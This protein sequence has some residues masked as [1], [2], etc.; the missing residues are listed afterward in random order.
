M[1][2]FIDVKSSDRGPT[3]EPVIVVRIAATIS[4]GDDLALI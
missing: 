4:R 1:L 2:H 3:V